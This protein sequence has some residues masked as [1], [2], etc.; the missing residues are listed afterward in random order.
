MGISEL[1]QAAI[2]ADRSDKAFD[3]LGGELVR[4][5]VIGPQ[6]ATLAGVVRKHC[7]ATLDRVLMAEGLAGQDDLLEAHARRLNSRR[8]SQDDLAGLT[9]ARPLTD[10]DPRVLI[11][12]TALPV[13]DRD[14]TDAVVSGRP[15]AVLASS[16]NAKQ[17]RI[18][19]A[20]PRA[21]QEEFAKRHRDHLTD[22]AQS[23]VPAL[24]SCR[25]WGD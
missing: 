4:Q 17:D 13:I 15:G 11:K 8:L 9:A 16:Q 14:S 22:L 7:D 24:E 20:D 19:L 12:H 1:R 23:R 25:T 2:G 6:D 21:V 3:T 18:L 10:H 5:G